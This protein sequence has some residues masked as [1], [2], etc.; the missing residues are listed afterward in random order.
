MTVFLKLVLLFFMYMDVLITLISVSYVHALRLGML[1][2]V[3]LTE[4]G[5]SGRAASVL[6][7]ASFQALTSYS[8]TCLGEQTHGHGSC[9]QLCF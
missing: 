8:Q 5:P 4:L 7:E 6:A 2:G 9:S 1:V 3:L